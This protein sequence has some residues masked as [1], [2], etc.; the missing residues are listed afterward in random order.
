ML[1]RELPIGSPNRLTISNRSYSISLSLQQPNSVEPD[2]LAVVA[3]APEL[4]ELRHALQQRVLLA[5]L[6]A[7]SERAGQLSPDES[8]LLALLPELEPALRPPHLSPPDRLERTE[9][10][11]P[12]P[13]L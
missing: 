3:R 13:K 12:E 6:Q 8:R 2:L 1:Q 4:R 7:E 10:G 11:Q 5:R 9:P